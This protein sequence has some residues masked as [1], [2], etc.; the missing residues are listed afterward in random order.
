MTRVSRRRGST[1]PPP[2]ETRSDRAKST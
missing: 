1:R 2:Q